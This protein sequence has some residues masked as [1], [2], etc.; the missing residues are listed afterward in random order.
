MAL[1]IIAELAD[2][3]YSLVL[4][5]DV[6]YALQT[7]DGLKARMAEVAGPVREDELCLTYMEA[8]N[9]LRDSY[10]K[11]LDEGEARELLIGKV[12]KFLFSSES[13]QE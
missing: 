6:T 4:A 13:R 10:E 2:K 7:V 5:N 11:N 1:L 3:N 8:L 9:K 12:D